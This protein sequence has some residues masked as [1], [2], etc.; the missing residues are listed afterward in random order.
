MVVGICGFNFQM[1]YM[2]MCQL[3]VQLASCILC[4]INTLDPRYN[5]AIGRRALYHV[6]Q[7]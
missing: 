5:A 1:N 7:K 3:T 6:I 4:A 2:Y